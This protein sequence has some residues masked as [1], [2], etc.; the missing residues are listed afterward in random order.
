MVTN[1]VLALQAANT[2]VYRTSHRVHYLQR[3][4]EVVVW[5]EEEPHVHNHL[6]LKTWTS[7]N[8]SDISME[9]TQVM[10]QGVLLRL[11]LRCIPGHYLQFL[12]P[13]LLYLE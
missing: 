12:P 3:E 4:E 11:I 5:A 13:L 10:A 6:Q 9:D 2:M 8:P 7:P 1:G